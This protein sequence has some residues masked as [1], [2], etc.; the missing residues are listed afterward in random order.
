V[1]DSKKDE[2]AKAKEKPGTESKIDIP[3][4]P[5]VPL[6]RERV[7][8]NVRG[9]KYDILVRILD[10]VPNGRLNIIK[11]VI[12]ANAKNQSIENIHTSIQLSFRR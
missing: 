12:E 4:K 9:N 10:N 5:K 3:A 6:S 1:F 2:N 11:H 8:L 7:I